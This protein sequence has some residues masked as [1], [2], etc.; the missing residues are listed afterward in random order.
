MEVGLSH[1][2]LKKEEVIKD[3]G[4][5]EEIDKRTQGKGKEACKAFL[6]TTCRR[7]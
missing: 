5:E 4:E 6:K 7:K 2:I 3:L 1:K